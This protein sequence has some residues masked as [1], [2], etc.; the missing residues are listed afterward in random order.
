MLNG[1]KP[2]KR[3]NRFCDEEKELLESR[4]KANKTPS[5]E[6]CASIASE[7]NETRK[8]KKAMKNGVEFQLTGKQIKFWFDHRRRIQ[9][10]GTY[11]P[12]KPGSRKK[13]AGSLSPQVAISKAMKN[14]FRTGLQ[15][16]GLPVKTDAPAPSNALATQPAASTSG[17]TAGTDAA[18]MT[19]LPHWMHSFQLLPLMSTMKY[20]TYNPGTVIIK[21]GELSDDLY[22][23]LKGCVKVIDLN[24]NVVA[25]L[26]QGSFFGEM[27]VIDKGPRTAT[28]VAATHCHA[29]VMS[30]EVARDML[31]CEP[32]VSK[33][34]VDQ[35]TS[36]LLD[37][38]KA[39][40]TSPASR[41]IGT[42][43]LKYDV[44][45]KGHVV[46]QEGEFTDDF[47]FLS[48]GSVMVTKQGSFISKLNQGTFF[49]E[50]AA[51][52]TGAR[53]TT[54]T[55]AEDC[56]VFMLPGEILRMLAKDDPALKNG[57][58]ETLR[59]VVFARAYD[60]MMALTDNSVRPT[61][62]DIAVS[63]STM[64]ADLK[65]ALFQLL[66]CIHNVTVS[67]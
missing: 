58:G 24:N 65:L 46:I 9:N 22:F 62:A 53:T 51:L 52:C 25:E 42:N 23:L 66:K 6:T 13:K 54:V 27:G 47:Y 35:A 45:K 12:L 38:L 39:Y 21:N 41:L 43:I 26:Q 29:F 15:Q 1:T 61:T 18:A 37:L 32:V 33:D 31:Q 44:Y 34:V 64:S 60:T 56:E 30:G 7:I 36:R 55:C 10:H 28:V 57:I 67:I 4:F 63:T 16:L 49:G 17:S 50:M 59:N 48:K 3:V 11:K 8:S 14:N 5:T 19:S 2:R 20:S 40:E